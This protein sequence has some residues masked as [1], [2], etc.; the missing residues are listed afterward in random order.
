MK[1]RA[2]IIIFIL[3]SIKK[4]KLLIIMVVITITIPKGVREIQTIPN[5]LSTMKIRKMVVML[6]KETT[7]SRGKVIVSLDVI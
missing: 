7:T 4:D 2:I 6:R 3:N 5:S 1:A